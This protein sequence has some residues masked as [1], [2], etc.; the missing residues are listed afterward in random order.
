MEMLGGRYLESLAGKK[1][2]TYYLFAMIEEMLEMTGLIVFAH[3][4]LHILERYRGTSVLLT[5]GSKASPNI[6]VETRGENSE[7]FST[8]QRIANKD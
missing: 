8:A 6:G 5:I 7:S 1:D 2:L 3:S 4:L